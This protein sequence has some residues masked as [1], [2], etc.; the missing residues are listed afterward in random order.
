MIV[1]LRHDVDEAYV[2]TR[3]LPKVISLEEK[4]GFRSTF[5]LYVYVVRSDRDCRVLHELLFNTA[6]L[7]FGGGRSA[8][9]A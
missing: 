2:L 3:S 4:Y 8:W 5:F 6:R 1:E 7:C 9:N